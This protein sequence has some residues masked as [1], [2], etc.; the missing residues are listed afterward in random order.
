MDLQQVC[1]H[2]GR[3]AGALTRRDVARGLLAVPAG[4]ALASLPALR[5]SLTVAGNPLSTAFWEHAEGLLTRIASGRVTVGDVRTW[6]EAT[7]TEPTML[8]AGGFLW[9]EE[10]ERGPVAEDMHAR[11]VAHLEGLVGAGVIDPDRL[12][13]GDEDAVAA[14]EEAQVAWLYQSLPDG[15]QPIWAVSDEEDEAFLAAWDDAEADAHAILSDLLAPLAPRSCP[16]DDLA[17]ACAGLR[18]RLRDGGWP[19]DLLAAAGG[20]DAGALPVDD[21]ELWLTL[22]AGVVECRD[23]PPEQGPDDAS[24]YAA[25][26]SLDHA[27][28][29]AAVVSLARAG[30][31]TPADASTLARLAATFDFEGELDEDDEPALLGADSGEVLSLEAGFG[32]VEL[33]WS[34]LGALDRHDRL[35]PLGWWGLPEALLL[36]WEPANAEQG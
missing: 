36:A 12:V 4:E 10:R 18:G 1:A 8:V 35:T 3:A 21:R 9:P 20:V 16:A 26:F 19:Y 30:P 23:E 2:A 28:W 22:A 13:A 24:A 29:I 27:A 15:R 32:T 5:R 31:G 7:G 34:A 14:Y 17:A 6:L 11:L 25:W 33:L